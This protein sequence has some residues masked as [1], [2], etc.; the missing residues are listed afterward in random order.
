[1]KKLK[2]N[3]ITAHYGEIPLPIDED[4]WWWKDKSS[5]KDKKVAKGT[6]EEQAFIIQSDNPL[7]VIMRIAAM[8]KIGWYRL[9]PRDGQMITDTYYNTQDNDL[10]KSSLRI[11]NVNGVDF[12]TIKGKNK[13]EWES[14]ASQVRSE[15]E[16]EWPWKT[17]SALDVANLFELKQ[18]QTRETARIVRDL[19]PNYKFKDGDFTPSAELA[20]DEVTYKF[21]ND[22]EA[23]FFE[24]EIELKNTSATLGSFTDL[25]LKKIPEL[26]KWKHSK[27]STGKTLELAMGIKF[28]EAN[29]LTE[30]SFDVIARLAEAM[31]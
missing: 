6:E 7:E 1:M 14:D 2:G 16:V 26:K 11:R 31:S 10:K 4:P 15:F 5:G 22:Q 8:E 23:R 3:I 18:V 30:D 12:I 20:L 17:P 29:L 28:D 25:F 21:A 19:V 27:L 13:K 24:V 9:I